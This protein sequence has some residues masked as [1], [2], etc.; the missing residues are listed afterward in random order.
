M[1]ST[2]PITI[3]VGGLCAFVAGSASCQYRRPTDPPVVF[4]NYYDEEDLVCDSYGYPHRWTSL[5]VLDYAKYGRLYRGC[6]CGVVEWRTLHHA[7]VWHQ[8]REGS[9]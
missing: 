8:L 5:A 6:I 2:I 9:P 7:A 3:I 1:K 4:E